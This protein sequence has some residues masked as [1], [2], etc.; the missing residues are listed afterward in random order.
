MSI[1]FS[2]IRRVI[3]VCSLAVAAVWT[4]PSHAQNALTNPYFDDDFSGWSNFYP[5]QT[6]ISRTMDYRT[7]DSVLIRSLELTSS[8]GGPP[9]FAFTS[10]CADIS[11]STVYIAA[12]EVYSHC[13]GQQVYLF[14]ADLSCNA[15]DA[16][17]AA[18][19]L[20]DEWGRVAAS[21]QSPLGTRKAVVVLENPATCD[22]AAY[23]DAITLLPDH[24]FTNGFERDLPP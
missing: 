2:A 24:I 4:I 22:G 15:G 5:G 21:A 3:G 17:M 11:E 20:I 1:D 13:P 14:W 8:E 10:Q 18:S 19:T 16:V 7:P 9:H 23:F 12:A 6:F